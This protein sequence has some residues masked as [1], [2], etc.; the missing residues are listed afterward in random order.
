[1]IS[2]KLQ[3]FG[4]LTLFVLNSLLIM[5]VTAFAQEAE[6][7][8]ESIEEPVKFELVDI[9][10][11]TQAIL[12]NEEDE[13]LEKS[14]EE[15]L[16][17]EEDLSEEI[18]EGSLEDKLEKLKEGEFEWEDLDMNTMSLE[19]PIIITPKPSE[20]QDPTAFL[21][22][23][24]GNYK[25]DLF[26]GSA[27]FTYPLWV[28]KGRT[29]ATTPIVNLSYSNINDRPDSL[30]GYGWTVSS[31]SIYRNATK[32]VDKLY[33][34][35]DFSVDLFGGVDQLIDVGSGTSFA[36]QYEQSFNNFYFSSGSWQMQDNMGH[37]YYFGSGSASQQVN[38][39]DSNEVSR[40]MLDRIQ[41]RN[42]NFITFTYQKDQ[43]QI[44]P[45]TIRYTGH[46]DGE[47]DV[48]GL[49]EIKFNLEDRDYDLTSYRT[50]YKVVTAKYINSV[51]V[52]VHTDDPAELV[53]TYDFT[54]EYS[55]NVLLLLKEIKVKNGAL[56]FPPLTFEYYSANENDQR[57]AVGLLKKIEFPGGATQEIEYKKSTAYR[58]QA[59]GISNIN[60][61]FQ[62]DTVSKTT[63]KESGSAPAA[64]YEYYY[65]GGHY[66]YDY[67]DSY[68]KEYAGFHTVQ[69]KDPEDNIH[70]TFFHQSEFSKDNSASELKGE[71][72][73]HLSKK[74][75]IY[76]EEVYDDVG[77]LFKATVNKWNKTALSDADPDK[78]RWFPF[79]ARTTEI[80][81]EGDVSNKAKAVEYTY[82]YLGMVTVNVD[83]GEVTLSNDKGDFSDVGEDK[84]TSEIEYIASG[85]LR[86]LP[87]RYESEDYYNNVISQKKIVYDGYSPHLSLAMW[88]NPTKVSVLFE[89]GMPTYFVTEFDYNVY[90][91]PTLYRNARSYETNYVYD[92][93]N[94]FPAE[95]TNAKS[96]TTTYT[97]NYGNQ[98]VG[99]I[100]D[101]NTAKVQYIYDTLGRLIEKKITD[102]AN[103][104][105]LVTVEETDYDLSV[106]PYSVTQTKITG[107]SGIEAVNKT[108][109]DGHSRPYQTKVE[110]E[111]S[112]YIVSSKSFDL[113]GRVKKEYLPKFTNTLAAE[114][115]IISDPATEYEYDA[116]D[117][118]IEITN[119]LGSSTITYDD[120]EKSV[121]DA[122]SNQKDFSYDARGNL[123]E[124]VEYLNSTPYTT[125]YQY[126]VFNKLTKI[127]DAVGN[128]RIL[129]YDFLGRL[130]SVTDLH[131]ISD[132]TY[133]YWGYQYDENNNLTLK[134]DP[135]GQV[136]F[137]TYDEIDR[138]MDADFDV[139]GSLETAYTYDSGT[140]G[141]GRLSSVTNTS[142][143]DK[144]YTYDILGRVI[145]EKKT[146]NT[147]DYDTAF[148]YDWLGNVLGMTYPNAMEVDYIYNNAGQLE[149]VDKGGNDLVTDIDYSPN[150]LVAQINYANGVS[151]VNTYDPAKL[152]RL[153]EKVTTKGMDQLQDISYEYDA[154]GNILEID[155]LSDQNSAKNAVYV[156]DDLYRLTSAT[157][158]N[159]ANSA[160]YTHTFDYDILGNILNKSD[161]GAYEYEGG[162]DLTSSAT[163]ATPHAATEV[164]SVAY[165]YDDNGNLTS[166][167][168]W[169]HD[170]NY[171]NRLA[172]ST[173]GVTT[174]DY[175]YDEAGQRFMKS[176]GAGDSIYLNEFVDIEDPETSNYILAG[177]MKVATVKA[178]PS[179]IPSDPSAE[180]PSVFS[181]ITYHSLDHLS[182]TN[183][184]TNESGGLVEVIDYFPFGEVRLDENAEGYD[185]NYKYTG[186]ELDE[187]T[188]L[189]YYE[190]RYYNSKIGRFVSQDE[191][192][193]DV[194]DPQ[195]LNKYSYVQNNPLKY[196]DTTGRFAE[197]A[198]DVVI[199]GYDFNR[200]VT[201]LGRTAWDGAWM[202]IHSLAGNTQEA[203]DISISYETNLGELGWSSLD[204]GIDVAAT[205]AP[206]VPAAI[207]K[208]DD[209]AK[210]VDKV[211][212]VNHALN[213][214][215][216]TV[217]FS[218]DANGAMNYVGITDNFATRSS[219]HRNN[220]GIEIQ[221][222]IENL[223][224]TDAR[225]VEQVL[226]EQHGLDN[227]LNQINSISKTNPIYNDSI[228][229]GTNILKNLVK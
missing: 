190:A 73:D 163:M 214:G 202:G 3:S 43:G 74:G 128:E 36:A 87:R 107:N 160:N 41:D 24:Q 197:T 90:G 53:R 9:D 207:T 52:L 79:L 212:D 205:A 2:K 111:G 150:G 176:S 106:T 93:Y 221:P 31:S 167:G 30:V 222:L 117:R 171:Q 137:Y 97:Y 112:D 35:N 84:V 149:A 119:S 7:M 110:A 54:Q 131:T 42:G 21:K 181:E 4:V 164:N 47:T 130:G 161:V 215:Q 186:K 115:I 64:V 70:K 91:L 50:G 154:V 204:L 63:L 75:R 134:A 155:D 12:E 168:T 39:A 172:S 113:N 17:N 147:I 225:A 129:E 208:V 71:F 45:E 199:T 22:G 124:V 206:F 6:D 139:T 153:T 11:T 34:E 57:N 20:P 44:Y 100:T 166:D 174:V 219:Q 58:T 26:S 182:G 55:N 37:T 177:G 51:D 148:E 105:A 19:D 114:A 152:W 192:F 102:P 13:L 92:T 99:E 121:T 188:G 96:Q 217:Y 95:I 16:K 68:K 72:E 143:I 10:E 210:T 32:G 18:I 88:G 66:Y 187:E 101:P 144:A 146:V 180:L 67:L 198:V 120:W 140:N 165:S 183:V 116:L 78:E 173:D 94:L 185:N 193:G 118:P 49:Y 82:N 89:P 122:N 196:V 191:W 213:S 38:S 203:A 25:T 194:N 223:N 27:N 125:A 218:N 211:N 5:P 184:D 77:N 216:T 80:D 201:N 85:A 46:Y 156:Y 175:F 220:K 1:L 138:V 103:A 229:K 159:T 209:I 178:V 169:T 123:I 224:R 69:L 28:P 227:L 48:P 195:S 65:E 40:W 179:P 132:S 151:T 29:D 200:T 8:E 56:E 136:I 226:I 108:Y 81:Y 59:Q 76:R 14:L 157:I 33:T 98:Q 126:N 141:I 60:L 61:P 62:I 83:Y 170:W 145:E 158:T 162:D 133:G 142:G 189:S 228:K 15:E 109:L 104:P 86:K 23:L 135:K 127:T